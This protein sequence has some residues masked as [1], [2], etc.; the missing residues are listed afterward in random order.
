MYYDRTPPDHTLAT[1]R[2]SAFFA[3]LR[4]QA[5]SSWGEEALS[6]IELRS[7]AN[8]PKNGWVQLYVGGTSVLELRANA[9]GRFRLHAHPDYRRTVADFPRLPLD[10]R[11]LDRLSEW[12]ERYLHGV[13][14]A[15]DDRYRSG[16]HAL[17]ARLVR[18]YSAAPDGP[19]TPVDTE[20]IV[21]FSSDPD[22]RRF[23]EE[24]RARMGASHRELD[25]LCVLPSGDIGLVELKRARDSIAVAARQAASHR[26]I[27]GRLISESRKRNPGYQLADTVNRHI[28]HKRALGLLTGRSHEA[29][30][31]ARLI[32]IV[33]TEDEGSGWAERWRDEIAAVR[34]RHPE[35]L[36]ALQLWRLDLEGRVLEVRPA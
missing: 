11:S 35:L 14:S 21:G 34:G 4:E 3:K 26:L 25:T 5:G 16:E 19:L 33:A 32:P 31:D 13:I 18:R 22:R 17:H 36:G 30:P 10:H 29:T 23:V 1:L 12:L 2:E 6:H 15:V 28:H 27:L 9:R 20:V 7:N 24:L 8:G